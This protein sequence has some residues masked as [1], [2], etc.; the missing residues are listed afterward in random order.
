[1][2]TLP[3]LET[4]R[5]VGNAVA[6][7]VVAEIPCS[8]WPARSSRPGAAGQQHDHTGEA[9]PYYRDE[10][11]MPNRWLVRVGGSRYKITAAVYHEFTDHVAL[12]L[13]S[14]GA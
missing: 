8:I 5:L 6:D 9:D 1:M 4:A 14:T 10:L 12:E 11:A 2:A 13:R 3:F 7:E